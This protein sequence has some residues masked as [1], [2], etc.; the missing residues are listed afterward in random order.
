M[1]IEPITFSKANLASWCI[2]HSAIPPKNLH[3][4]QSHLEA[5]HGQVDWI[6]TIRQWLNV[7]S[8]KILTDG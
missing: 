1:G 7:F 8:N 3:Y 6:E 5:D 2:C 4:T